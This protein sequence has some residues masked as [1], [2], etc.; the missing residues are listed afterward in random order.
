VRQ[1]EQTRV[2]SQSFGEVAADYDRLRPEPPAEAL[3][4]LLPPGARDVVELG[5]GTGILTRLLIARGLRVQAIEPDARMREVL[6]RRAAGAEIVAGR[7]E[8]LPAANASADTVIA[9]SAWHWVDEEKAV[10][11]VARV[12]RPGGSLSLLWCG[13]D[14]RVDWMR[15]L[16]AGGRRLSTEEASAYD[17]GRRHRH[18]VNL[19]DAS[20]FGEPETTVFRWTRSMS[21]GDL[22]G[23]ALTYSAVITMDESERR[24][25]AERMHRFL[26]DA[27]ELAG[28]EVIDVP[29]RCLCWRSVRH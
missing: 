3:D 12:L 23:L 6:G 21:K 5:A 17:E 24:D 10:P 7:A 22:V 4:W 29:M 26:S 8:E 11:E 14:R 18:A 9:S 19:G 16:W 27:E 13:P 20:L 1:D 28:Q 15:S 2:R 25:Y